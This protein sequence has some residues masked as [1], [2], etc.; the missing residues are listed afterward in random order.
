M[1]ARKF[2][3]I[4]IPPLLAPGRQQNGSTV[5]FVA[6]CA[7]KPAPYTS[8]IHAFLSRRGWLCGSSWQENC[9]DAPVF[10]LLRAAGR[11]RPLA[12][13]PTRTSFGKQTR[14]M[15]AIRSLSFDQHHGDR[16]AAPVGRRHEPAT[17]A[18][19]RPAPYLQLHC[20]PQDGRLPPL[21]GQRA[22]LPTCPTM[23]PGGLWKGNGGQTWRPPCDRRDRGWSDG[24]P[25]HAPQRTM[26]KVPD[27]PAG[28]E[29]PSLIHLT[30]T[31]LS[32]AVSLVPAAGMAR[33]S[34]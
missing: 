8:T 33:I 4:A 30:R 25:S 12:S 28:H 7:H 9:G 1:S 29:A 31:A 18:S 13:P 3:A 14:H 6:L 2:L 34:G 26:L 27:A 15:A 11:C 20:R 32:S 16:P 10:Q 22:P 17:S 21:Q 23:R 24:P 5:G 19:A